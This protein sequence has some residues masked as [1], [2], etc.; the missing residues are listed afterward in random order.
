MNFLVL[1]HS[2]HYFYCF[3][4]LVPV[5]PIWDTA[6]KEK[7]KIFQAVSLD[8]EIVRRDGETYIVNLAHSEEESK[9]IID[10]SEQLINDGH[11]QKKSGNNAGNIKLN[12]SS[13]KFL[14]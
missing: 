4:D 14:Q 10:V 8:A 9:Q 5:G 6:A 7:L 12:Y 11:A 13:H 1:S 3:T 2:L